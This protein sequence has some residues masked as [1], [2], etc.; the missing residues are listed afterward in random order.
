MM[1]LVCPNCSAQYE[2]DGS[3]IPDEGRDVQCSNC[4]HTWFELPPPSADF[5]EAVAE[6]YEEPVVDKPAAEEAVAARA[7]RP[8]RR[9]EEGTSETV[10]E[11]DEADEAEEE[12]ADDTDDEP[13]SSFDDEFE[14][15]VE[16]EDFD[17]PA[18]TDDTEDPDEG[19]VPSDTD[20]SDKDGPEPKV[21][22]SDPQRTRRI[23][24]VVA[25]AAAA[26]SSDDH[27]RDD[28]EF[29]SEDSVP[30][31][32]RP[33]RPADAASLDILKEEAERE[34]SQRRA[35]PSSTIETQTD[36]GLDEIRNRHSPS[37]ALRARMAHLGEAA[38]KADAQPQP[39]ET[40]TDFDPPKPKQKRQTTPEP[41][42]DG[43]YVEPRRDLLPDI[44]EINSTL[45]P[46][47]RRSRRAPSQG[48]SGFLGGF[49]LMMLITVGLIFAYAQAPALA[50]ALPGA[51]GTL[52]AYV[53]NANAF[54]DWVQSLFGD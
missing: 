10:A 42:D 26:A 28:D 20:K 33:R 25:A 1:R 45:K 46:A 3:M 51:E 52:I 2:I 38:P 11:A 12:F 15:T 43:D 53:D 21:I 24:E 40:E 27:K 8:D 6:D 22:Y 32:Q 30:E 47:R 5:G 29:P 49:V 44:D 19:E 23:S 39:E 34:L 4:G 36:L 48:S 50:R 7:D 31:P 37:R 16:A 41:E 14:E 9:E 54:R 35:P 13:D 18:E 17:E